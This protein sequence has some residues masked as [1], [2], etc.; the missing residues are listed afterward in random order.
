MIYTRLPDLTLPK[1][2]G[3]HTQWLEFRDSFQSVIVDS[4]R[5]SNVDKFHYLK[6]CLSQ[7]VYL[8][9][10]SIPISND[11]FEIAWKTLCSRFD[12]PRLIANNHID[13]LF[14][15]PQLDK[16]DPAPLQRFLDNYISNTNALNQLNISV[17]LSDLVISKLILD[18]LPH[19]YIREWE[20]QVNHNENPT[21]QDLLEFIKTRVIIAEMTQNTTK[22]TSHNNSKLNDNKPQEKHNAKPNNHTNQNAFKSNN[23]VRNP[24]LKC[25]C[26]KQTGHTE[27]FHCQEFCPG[28]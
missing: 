17:P 23:T 2:A 14:S 8:T 18:K 1:Y 19:Y 16:N 28:M 24:V 27:L 25:K 7:E 22:I 26:C 21:L 4:P 3:D 12:N 20:T 10:I 6:G 13:K 5:L 11:N 9:I 15:P